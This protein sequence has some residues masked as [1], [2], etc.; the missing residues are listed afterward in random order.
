MSNQK[1]LLGIFLSLGVAFCVMVALSHGSTKVEGVPV[2]AICCAIAFGV[3]WLMF[4]PAYLLK[5]E[6]FYD[7]TGAL[8]HIT[9]VLVA[10]VS[11]PTVSLRDILIA[12]LVFVWASRLGSFLFLRVR[13]AGG[14]VRFKKIK[15]NFLMFLMT[16]TL[17]GLWVF[18]TLAMALAAITSNLKKD[19]DAFA[20]VGL[21]V[22]LFGFVFEV[23]ADHQKSKFRR[24]SKNKGAFIK[25]GLWSWSRHPNYFGEIVLWVGIAILAAPVLE[26]WQWVGLI[27]PVFVAFL[28][29]RVSGVGLLEAQGTERWGHDPGYQNYIARTSIL[30]PF[31]PASES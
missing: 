17:Q 19:L 3:Q 1:S 26:G 20:W 16:W 7:A 14:D 25:G 13:D 6:H 24:D 4:M 18:L 28:L 22:W 21:S 30:I 31:P 15:H 8:T 29:L 27:S 23:M 12:L 10:I 11:I 2:I 9:I 5:T